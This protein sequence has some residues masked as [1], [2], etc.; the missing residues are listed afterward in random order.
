MRSLFTGYLPKVIRE[1]EPLFY[2]GFRAM[3]RCFSLERIAP[4]L[5]GDGL[6]G[7]LVALEHHA[8]DDLPVGAEPEADTGL[9]GTGRCHDAGNSGCELDP[10]TR[11]REIRE[12]LVLEGDD[13]SLG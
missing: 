10:A 9:F 4:G 1:K 6:E 12:L 3:S 2:C 7:G 8:I 11:D 5:A 13:S